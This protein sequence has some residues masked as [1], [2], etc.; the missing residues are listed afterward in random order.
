MGRFAGISR[1]FVLVAGLMVAISGCD[2]AEDMG[3]KVVRK[4]ERER[5]KLRSRPPTLGV[6]QAEAH[7]KAQDFLTVVHIRSSFRSKSFGP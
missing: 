2:K 1:M 4:V 5:G 3:R 7:Q 6:M